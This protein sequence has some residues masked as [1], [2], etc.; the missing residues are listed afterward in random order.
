MRTQ[1]I[2]ALALP[3]SALAQQPRLLPLDEISPCERYTY[4]RPLS[5][6]TD[7]RSGACVCMACLMIESTQEYVRVRMSCDDCNM[8]T[9][10]ETFHMEVAPAIRE[11]P[12]P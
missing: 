6:S 11:T 3:L 10:G 4:I 7:P 2:I 5:F 1:S 9:P 12:W 8:A